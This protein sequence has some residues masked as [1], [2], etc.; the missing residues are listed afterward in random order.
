MKKILALL[1][2]LLI[3]ATFSC[4]KQEANKDGDQVAGGKEAAIVKVWGWRTQD[5]EVWKQ[6]QAAL[7][8]KG[9]NIVIEYE[10]FV[11]AEYDSKALLSL[12]GGS[13]SDILYTRRLPGE[14][15]QGLIDNGFLVPLDKKIDLSNIPETTLNSIRSGGEVWGVPF[16]NQ[17]VGIFY[18]K[19]IFDKYDFEEPE[20]WDELLNISK[21]LK[22]DGITPF[23]IPGKAGWALAMQHAMVGVSEPGSDWIGELAKGNAKFT[24][25][26]FVNIGKRLNDL[27]Q[28]YQK[29]FIAN[30]TDEMSAGFALEQTAM[31]F[32]G[33]WGGSNWKKLN[34]EFNYGYFPVPV[35]KKGSSPS[36]YVYMDGSY[37][38]NPVSENKE[39]ALKVLAFAASPE[40]GTIFSSVTGEMTAVRGATLPKD[41]LVLQECYKTANSMAAENMYWV[42][43]VFQNGTP[44]VYSILSEKMQSMYL[45]DIT[46]E[47]LAQDIQVGLASWYKPLQ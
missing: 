40:F 24:D 30:S 7:Q 33:I 4:K 1:L 15:T 19:D 6:T 28:Y 14:R 35:V 44:T 43:S 22:A 25:S 36:V 9:D 41:R 18:N 31:V 26:E 21:K 29:D 42:G 38:L 5:A 37:G 27:K 2:V 46:P 23:M 11:P 39:A 45:D 16:A 3:L 17:V 20:T 32:Y 12:Q 13:A 47:Q 8:A 34:P 10:S